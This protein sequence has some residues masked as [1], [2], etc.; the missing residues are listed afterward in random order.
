V[1]YSGTS[2][3]KERGMER[4]NEGKKRERNTKDK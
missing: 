1:R 2:I 4:T 3:L